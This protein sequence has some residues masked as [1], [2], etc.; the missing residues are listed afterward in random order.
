[1][2]SLVDHAEQ[3]QL[4]LSELKRVGTQQELLKKAV[5]EAISFADAQGETLE[6]AHL[7]SFPKNTHVQLQ[8]P[9]IQQAVPQEQQ[10]RHQQQQQQQQLPA[11]K[12]FLLL[13]GCF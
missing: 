12:P 7:Q 4:F 5:S 10:Q 2:S 3:Q 9:D 11:G 6:I 13:P 1:M 8:Q